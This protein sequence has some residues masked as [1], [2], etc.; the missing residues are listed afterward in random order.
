MVLT[1]FKKQK[2]IFHFISKRLLIEEFLLNF[3]LQVIF[4]K[5][6]YEAQVMRLALFHQKPEAFDSPETW[7]Y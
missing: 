7:R 1:E 4:L 5:Q 6:Y 2:N 3:S